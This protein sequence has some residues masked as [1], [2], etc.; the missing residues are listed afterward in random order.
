MI[1]TT[2]TPHLVTINCDVG[3]SVVTRFIKIDQLSGFCFGQFAV[4]NSLGH[5]AAETVM[6][7]GGT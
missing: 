3:V 5:L 2:P 7:D 6:R 4:F 1:M